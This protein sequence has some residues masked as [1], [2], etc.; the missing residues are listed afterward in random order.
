MIK[1]FYNKNIFS[2]FYRLKD[3]TIEAIYGATFGHCPTYIFSNNQNMTDENFSAFIEKCNEK[4]NL[5]SQHIDYNSV[6]FSLLRN[7]IK[8]ELKKHKDEE[9]LY[10]FSDSK[11]KNLFR[12]YYREN[13]IYTSVAC[14]DIKC[15]DEFVEFIKPYIHTTEKPQIGVFVNDG[16]AIYVKDLDIEVPDVN[17]EYNYG[18]KFSKI[19]DS[20]IDKLSKKKSGL[21][22]FHGPPGTGKTTYIKYLSTKVKRKFVF[23]PSGLIN[24][25]VDPSFI[26]TLINDKNLILIIEDAEKAIESR[27][28]NS[29]NEGFV[30]TILNLSNGILGDI[31]NISIIITFNTHKEKIDKALL[32]KGRLNMIHEF[33]KLT[34]EESEKLVKFLG[35]EYNIQEPMVLGDIFNIEEVNGNEIIKEERKIGFV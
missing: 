27:E 17:I 24:C 29:G 5:V 12:F 23:L 6:T 19:N 30:S 31:L 21:Y 25:L 10:I 28:L 1:S 35:K 15:Y 33:N 20:I 18:E 2:D 14:E 16:Q 4:Y 3:A 9:D 22:I 13:S 26:S 34:I 7:T 32:R 8:A 11:F